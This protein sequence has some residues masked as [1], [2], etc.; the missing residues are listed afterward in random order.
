[1][2]EIKNEPVVGTPSCSSDDGGSPSPATHLRNVER[3]QRPRCPICGGQA[4]NKH[5]G[6]AACNACAAFFR[7][8]VGQKQRHTCAHDKSCKIQTGEGRHFCKF[9]RFHKCISE[10]MAPNAV[11][12]ARSLCEVQGVDAGTELWKIALA[13][14]A[15]FVN[16]FRNIIAAYGTSE[17]VSPVGYKDPHFSHT[18]IATEAEVHVLFDYMKTSGIQELGL[19]KVQF[20]QLGGALFYPWVSYQGVMNTLRNS[21]H[22]TNIAFATDESHMAIDAAVVARYVRTCEGF[23]DYDLVAKYT[24]K[25]FEESVHT[26][27]LLDAM[28]MEDAE[29]SVWFHLFALSIAAR[30]F[31]HNQE[32]RT[33]MNAL[34]GFLRSHYQNNHDDV[35]VRVGNIVLLLAEL[36][37][38]TNLFKDYVAILHLN[39][40]NSLAN[41]LF[42]RA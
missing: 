4:L 29:H 34:F 11:C 26:V 9:H 7:R 5:F 42:S 3:D 31:P 37:R 2:L 8:T 40:Y 25:C 32:I 18:V 36:E 28:R 12:A 30:M 14:R 22:K 21:G 35:A 13:Q 15:T 17:G 1:M 38:L 41:R 20:M 39:G 10:G 27:K 19:N 24:M 33:R 23:L 6:A 16:R